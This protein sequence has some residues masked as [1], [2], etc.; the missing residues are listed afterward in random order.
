MPDNRLL[1]GIRQI[2]SANILNLFFSVGTAFLL[3]KFLPV[4]SYAQIKTYQLYISYIAIFHLGYNDG[5]YLK[6]GG[7]SLS[8]IDPDELQTDLSTLRI[9]QAGMTLLCALLSIPFRDTA[10]FMAACTILPMNA[11]AYYKNLYQ[12]AGEFHIYSRVLNLTTGVTFLINAL[13]VCVLQVSQDLFYLSGYVLLNVGIWIY[14]ERTFCRTSQTAPVLTRFDPRLL[15]LHIS[16]GFSLLL[17]NMASMLLTG[18]DRMFVKGLLGTIPFAQYA[19]AASMEN[20]LNTVVTPVS[21]SLYPYFCTREDENE[22]HRSLELIMAFAGAAVI[23]AFPVRFLLETVLTE[24]APSKDVLFLLFAAQIFLIVIKCF[25]VNLYKARKEQQRYFGRLCLVIVLAVALNIVCYAIVPCKESFAVAT[26]LAAGGWFLLCQLDFKDLAL[27]F[28]H[29]FFL[30]SEALLL[31]FCGCFL[32]LFPGL[33]L[34]GAATLLLVALCLPNV[35]REGKDL[36][37]RLKP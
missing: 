30:S 2:L 12:A 36:L 24:Y 27:Q 29:Y 3:P 15:K 5:M 19:F 1:R 23:S 16:A 26:L 4:E 31:I 37:S 11:I 21:I 34:Y 33:F 28:R 20:F 22:L 17:G 9:F 32:P 14:L 35:L 25:Y 13:L 7:K 18:I 8:V 6:Y 10:L